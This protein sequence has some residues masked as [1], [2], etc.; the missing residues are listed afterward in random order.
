MKMRSRFSI[1]TGPDPVEQ[2]RVVNN[3]KEGGAFNIVV[4]LHHVHAALYWIS[5]GE[6]SIASILKDLTINLPA[7]VYGQYE[8]KD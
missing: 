1:A 6:S 3:L 7:T 8:V 5:D 4:G 2:N